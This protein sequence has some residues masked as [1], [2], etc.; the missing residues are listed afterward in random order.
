MLLLLPLGTTT[1]A[2]VN[3][4]RALPLDRES[5]QEKNWYQK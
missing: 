2:I 5:N 1:I 4:G 3:G